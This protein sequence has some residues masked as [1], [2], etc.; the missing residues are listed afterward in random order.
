MAI[1]PYSEISLKKKDPL[2]E[3][4]QIHNTANANGILEKMTILWLYL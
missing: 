2:F 4:S 1:V 3:I